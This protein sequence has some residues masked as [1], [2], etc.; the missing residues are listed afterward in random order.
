MIQLRDTVDIQAPPER[1]WAWLNELP[2]HYR[3]WHPAHI[4]CRYIRGDNLAVGAVLQVNEYL[5]EKPHSLMLH[6]DVVVPDRLLRYSGRGFRGAFIL[7]PVDEGTRFTAELE[8]GICLPLGGRL[9]DVVLRRVLA[10]R[11]SAF[12]THMREEGEN[13][14]RLLEA[15]L[16]NET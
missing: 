7:E 2:H 10:K 14:R 9:L 4:D 5:H 1:V 15:R 12:Q 3:D 13:L 6:A 8:F 16:A 11:L